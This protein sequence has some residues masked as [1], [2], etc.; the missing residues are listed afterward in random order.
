MTMGNKNMVY[1]GSE[2]DLPEVLALQAGPVKLLYEQGDIRS[3]RL[4]NCEI[5]RRIYVALRDRNWN[6]VPVAITNLNTRIEPGGFQIEY[7]AEHRQ[8][9]IDFTWHAMLTGWAGD[10]ETRAAG[11][12]AANGIHA[13]TITFHLRGV[14]RT[15]FWRNRIGFCVLHPASL[16]GQPCR[17]EHNDGVVEEAHF[18][19]EICALQPV[20]GLAEMK[21]IQYP[22]GPGARAE[23]EFTGDSFETEDQRNWTDASYKTFSTPLRLPYP[24]EIKAG[25]R[26]EQTILLRVYT[27]AI[28]RA[29]ASAQ[30]EEAPRLAV[31]WLSPGQPMPALGL[32][33]A[34]HGQPLSDK[35][36]ARL[37][38]L[39]LQHLRV[40]LPLP[41]ITFPEKLIRAAREAEQLGVA[42]EVAI[43]APAQAEAQWA[44]LRQCLERLRPRVAAWLCTPLPEI[45][46]GGSPVVEVV[47][48][49]RR[50][51]GDYAPGIPL[52][53]G[54]NADLIFLK[55]SRPPLEI[56]QG[57]CYT[58]SPQVHAFDN[59][60]LV[61]TLEIQ[62][63]TVADQRAASAGWLGRELPIT[64][65]PITLKLR[66]NPYA[67]GLSS[68]PAPGA[69]PAEVDARQ[70]SLFGAGWTA[71]SYQ[72]LAAAGAAR[73]TY[74]ETTGW[75]GVMETEAGA[76][77]PKAFPSCPGSVY[78][79]YHVLADIGEFAGG[80]VA[81]VQANRPLL[82]NGL[83]L[84]QG[85]RRRL[86][87]FNHTPAR[88]IVR[89]QGLAEQG[90]GRILD[91]TNGLPA[92]QAPEVYRSE[93]SRILPKMGKLALRPYAVA[94]LDVEQLDPQ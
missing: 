27:Q 48:A 41:E 89:L 49:A 83:A 13:A 32:E 53:A 15:T 84:R 66:F 55:R 50:W 19:V 44:E 24:V 94:C 34:S 46:T 14:A 39:R 23:V 91:E 42:L 22:V 73:L 37:Q 70:L 47:Q 90:R 5:I 6:T 1:Y 59:T 60:S 62:G 25:T 86:L 8:A 26:I 67:T 87:V 61:E 68:E 28:P 11:I 64:V 85:H 12:I 88:Q 20:P 31:D 2:Q 75:R 93:A 58:I 9:E 7:D 45:F 82:V 92:M 74:Y 10:G 35:E 17:I 81:P 38:A 79:L 77:Q 40:S 54:T 30:A 56:I 78:P 57:L 51:L 16:A 63:T 72:S 76:P 52:Y 21:T 33:M 65:S 80:T 3:I 43:Q 71:G 4:G 36:I 69:L 29:P 18:P